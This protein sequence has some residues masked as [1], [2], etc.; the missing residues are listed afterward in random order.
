M[1][2][3]NI[4]LLEDWKWSTIVV[5]NVEIPE[6]CNQQNSKDKEPVIEEPLF[7]EPKTRLCHNLVM[8]VLDCVSSWST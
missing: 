4:L 1:V 2:Y 8:Q 5:E 6:H 7:K 3:F